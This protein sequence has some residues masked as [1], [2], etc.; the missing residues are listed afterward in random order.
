MTVKKVAKTHTE[1]SNMSTQAPPGLYAPNI[2]QLPSPVP[3]M[4]TVMLPRHIYENL[5]SSHLP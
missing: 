5:V 1:T 2:P 4:E 3:S